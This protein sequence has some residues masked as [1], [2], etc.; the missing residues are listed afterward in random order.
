MSGVSLPFY[1]L[2]TPKGYF[3][4][5]R[6][7]KRLH[8]IIGRRELK[9]AIAGTDR[10]LAERQAILYAAQAF[11]LFSSLE[12]TPLSEHRF[13]MVVEIGGTKIHLDKDN[14]Q[15]EVEILQDR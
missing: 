5:I 6:V 9:K 14:L 11:A 2:L 3:F 13:D 8:A 4:R 7:P 1:L 10:H 15:K 12:D